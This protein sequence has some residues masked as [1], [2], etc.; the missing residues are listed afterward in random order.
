MHST[1]IPCHSVY[2]NRVFSY[3]VNEPNSRCDIKINARTL[4]SERNTLLGQIDFLLILRYTIFCLSLLNGSSKLDGESPRF[5]YRIGICIGFI[6]RMPQC[7]A[8]GEPVSSFVL[9]NGTLYLVVVAFQ[10]LR[11]YEAYNSH[12]PLAHSCTSC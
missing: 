7:D 10:N 11:E 1:H 3:Y 6:S 2:R 9:H 12:S 5:R 4:L 8:Y